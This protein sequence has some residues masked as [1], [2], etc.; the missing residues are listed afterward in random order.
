[1]DSFP[2][3]INNTEA[4]QYEMEVE[5][6]L[7]YVAYMD[8]GARI[9]FHHT[10]VPAHLGGKGIG[11]HLAK[12]VLEAAKEAEKVV[13]PICPFIRAYI[14]RHPEYKAIVSPGYII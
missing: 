5:G 14:A 7:A 12:H 1:M 11:S 6:A 3:I 9:V 4:Q 2:P 10:E 13:V 8:R